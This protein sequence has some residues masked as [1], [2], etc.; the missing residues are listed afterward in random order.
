MKHAVNESRILVLGT[1]GLFGF[2]FRAAFEPGFDRL[3]AIMQTAKLAGLGLLVATTALLMAPAAYHQ[4]VEGG[5]DTRAVHRFASGTAALALLPFALALA[6]DL[7][8]AGGVV[9]GGRGGHEGEGSRSDGRAG[10]DPLK[11]KVDHVLTETRVPPPPR[12]SSPM[13]CGSGSRRGRRAA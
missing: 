13:A 7:S 10:P 1:Q 9:F 3:P 4:I 8:L 5:S 12:S 11:D 6:I 2:H